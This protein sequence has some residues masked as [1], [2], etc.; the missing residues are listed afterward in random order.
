MKLFSPKGRPLSRATARNATLLNLLGT[1]GLGSLIARRWISGTLQLLVFLT[2]F[3]LF[4]LWSFQMIISYYKQA[5]SSE[6]PPDG[7]W[8]DIAL[9]GVALCVVAWIWS[10]LTSFSLLQE[11]STAGQRSLENFAAPPV[12]KLSDERIF[13]E[14]ALVPQ[15]QLQGATIMRTFEFKDFP[16]AI[17]FVDTVAVIAEHE[18]HHPDIDVRWNK[19]TLTLTSHDA[20]GLTEKDFKLAR[21]FDKL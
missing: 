5:V 18:W 8:G 14:L 17:K 13:P 12:Q 7:H 9:I 20:G 6:P 19:V 16:A 1:P 11:A 4:C 21:Q 2:G 3:V 10:A 15:W